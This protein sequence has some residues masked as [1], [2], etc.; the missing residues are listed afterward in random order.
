M[1]E[2]QLE[3]DRRD[4]DE[5]TPVHLASR[6]H[7]VDGF[8]ADH[9][10]INGFVADH[11]R[12]TGVVA[13]DGPEL[14]PHLP[15]ASVRGIAGRCG[16]PAPFV[17]SDVHGAAQAL[18]ERFDV[19]CTGV[20]ALVWLPDPPRWARVV[21]DLLV[22]GGV[23][24]LR[25]DHPVLHAQDAGRTDGELV[26]RHDH[27]D[28]G[29]HRDDEA[30]TCTDGG[31]AFAHP[32]THQW[33]HPLADGARVLDAGLRLVAL[34]EHRT[35]AWPALPGMVEVDGGRALPERRERPPSATP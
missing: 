26:L 25:E 6:V 16:L 20:G 30:A 33:S 11:I 21:A 28:T 3:A 35:L 23:L 18:G 19:V 1:T 24:H 13:L 17:R 8:V 2:G 4:R 9:I 32:T 10:R 31:A 12:I 14:V 34:R 29:P 15:G 22:P 27:F 7:D 5:R